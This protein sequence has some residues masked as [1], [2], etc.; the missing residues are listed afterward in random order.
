M[1]INLN[2]NEFLLVNYIVSEN[3]KDEYKY[4]KE[5]KGKLNSF[6]NLIFLCNL[7]KLKNKYFMY[8]VLNNNINFVLKNVTEYT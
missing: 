2:N 7:Y 1:G 4:K 8:F 6:F 3:K 5:Y